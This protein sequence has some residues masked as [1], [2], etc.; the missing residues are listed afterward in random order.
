MPVSIDNLINI[1]FTKAR[2]ELLRFGSKLG[3]DGAHKPYVPLIL[4]GV[5]APQIGSIYVAH[6]GTRPYIYSISSGSIDSNTGE[7]KSLSLTQ[8]SG[9]ITVTDSLFHVSTI[10]V[11]FLCLWVRQ[12]KISDI[13]QALYTKDMQ[14]FIPQKG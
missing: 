10:Q 2:S 9:V 14:L 8:D 3:G 5:E 7:I 6:G 13:R 4:S 1:N 12:S 11:F